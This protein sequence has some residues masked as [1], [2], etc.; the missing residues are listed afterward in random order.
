MRIALHTP[1]TLLLRP[2]APQSGRVFDVMLVLAGTLLTALSA[3]LVIPLRPALSPVPIT[4]QTF[5]VLLL[6]ATFG[7]RRAAATMAAY[8]MEGVVGLPVFA[9]GVA[10]AAV[11]IGPTAGYLIGFIPAAALVGLLAERGF[12]RRPLTTAIA[13]ILGM[14]VIHVCGMAWLTMFVG[15]DRI[16]VAGLLP[17]LPGD[18]VKI[19]LAMALLPGAWLALGLLVGAPAD[20]KPLRRRFEAPAENAEQ[21]GDF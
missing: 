8:V 9:G 21:A 5:A 10:G 2:S 6:G 15:M 12:D 4:G 13:M 17:F 20:P 1:L 18:V 19:A 11:L 16:I 7:S 3:Q 14:L